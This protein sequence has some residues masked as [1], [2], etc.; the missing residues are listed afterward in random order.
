MWF[1]RRVSYFRNSAR[2]KHLHFL[3]H[4]FPILIPSSF[5]GSSS[6]C[7]ASVCLAASKPILSCSSISCEG[8]S[9]YNPQ[10]FVIHQQGH[11]SLGPQDAYLSSHRLSSFLSQGPPKALSSPPLH[12]NTAEFKQSPEPRVL[13]AP[14]SAG[15]R[16]TVPRTAGGGGISLGF[17]DLWG[18]LPFRPLSFLWLPSPRGCL[19]SPH[20]CLHAQLSVQCCSASQRCCAYFWASCSGWADPKPCPLCSRGPFCFR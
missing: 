6:L 14:G 3:S 12:K 19:P 16:C 15:V 9:F 13:G 1:G 2:K 17:L 18:W 11:A 7:P 20:G 10:A 8:P 5:S 4:S